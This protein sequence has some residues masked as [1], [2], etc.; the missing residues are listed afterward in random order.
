MYLGTD[1]PGFY[2]KLGATVH[3]Q[4]S[5]DF[6]IMLLETNSPMENADGQLRPIEPTTPQGA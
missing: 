1:N 2:R 3:E 4:L 6:S 5:A